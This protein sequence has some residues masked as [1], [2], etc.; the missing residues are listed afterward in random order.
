MVERRIQCNL[1]I[2]VVFF[3]VKFRVFGATTLLDEMAQPVDRGPDENDTAHNEG[4]NSSFQQY[5]NDCY[6]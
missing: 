2:V 3:V 1:F 4:N 5:E 6:E